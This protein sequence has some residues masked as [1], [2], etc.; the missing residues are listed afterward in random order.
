M[1]KE[2]V[3]VGG[4]KKSKEKS[5]SFQFY[6]KELL[7][8]SSAMAM[9]NE[10]VGMYLKLLCFD[11]MN[12]GIP[13]DK[14]TIMRLV[15]FDWTDFQGKDRDIKDYEICFSFLK[16][17]FVPHPNRKGFLTNLRLMKERVRQIENSK[18]RS[19]AGKIGI[20]KR[21][22][23]YNLANSKP[24]AK[25]IAKNSLP[26]PSP[27]PSPSVSSSASDSANS[28]SESEKE[29]YISLLQKTEDFSDWEKE[30]T[31]IFG[32]TVTICRLDGKTAFVPK[33][34]EPYIL[35]TPKDKVVSAY[36][37]MIG[38]KPWDRSWDKS[39][40]GYG[41]CI[42]AAE[43]LLSDLETLDEVIACVE[44]C[45]FYFSEKKLDWTLE[46]VAKRAMDWKSGRI[47]R[48]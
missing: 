36:K 17:R 39:K 43:A 15:G 37:Q 20:T 12:D 22:Q 3:A 48:Q 1:L 47:P 24:I 21:W 46:T 19:E 14:N 2:A 29:T 18:V 44:D 41:R 25:H 38:V 34:G 9:P 45:A 31:E 40:Y 26:F 10:V 30:D 35:A 16:D 42:K 5:P 4:A 6:P 8:D 11:W 28:E 23:S 27:S 13:D 33:D 7:S 32:E